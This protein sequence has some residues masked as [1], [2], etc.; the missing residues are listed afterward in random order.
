MGTHIFPQSE[1]N[2]VNDPINVSSDTSLSLSE[3]LSLPSTPYLTPIS[4]TP[5]PS[6]FPTNLDARYGEKSTN[7]IKIRLDWNTFVAPPASIAQNHESHRLHKWSLNRLEYRQ[8]IHKDIHVHN[9]Q[10]LTQDNLTL[11]IE[12]TVK[13]NY[14]IHHPLLLAPPNITAQSL[15]PP[16]IPQK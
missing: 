10:I 3:T 7:N 14:S 4:Q 9:K 15:P 2:L 12:I 8:D 11:K 13:L 1:A 6:Y 5:F 16:F